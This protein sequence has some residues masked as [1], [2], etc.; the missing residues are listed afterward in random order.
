MFVIVV[1]VIAAAI[2]TFLI[3]AAILEV[4]WNMT[5]P[6]VFGLREIHYWQSV[7]LMLISA[8]LFS[9]SFVRFNLDG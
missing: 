5:M 9:P 2:V 8:I 3:L 6:D 7:R 1:L 4:L